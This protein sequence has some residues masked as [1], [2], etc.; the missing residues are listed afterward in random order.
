MSA[1]KTPAPLAPDA[2]LQV[3]Q[4]NSPYGVKGWVWVY[5]LTEPM[6]NI[7]AYTPWYLRRG[8]RFEAVEVAEWR[9]Q[10]K[11]VVARLKGCDDRNAVE[12]LNGVEIW[13]PKDILPVL[14][15]GDYYWSELLDMDV[16]TDAGVFLGRVHSM[17]ETGANDVLVVQGCEGSIDRQERLIPWLPDQVVTG[18]DRTLRRIT[19]DWDPEF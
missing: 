2:L 5:A 17:M 19:V 16:W 11:G 14:G 6:D 4:I 1:A 15:D 18:V 10:G 8:G 9:R 13:V 12:L 7:F 3:G